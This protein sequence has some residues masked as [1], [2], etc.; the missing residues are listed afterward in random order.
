MKFTVRLLVLSCLAMP[1][2]LLAQKAD[3]YAYQENAAFVPGLYEAARDAQVYL[4]LDA[5]AVE[6]GVFIKKGTRISIYSAGHHGAE[7]PSTNWFN[8]TE[9]QECNGKILAWDN[10]G[11]VGVLGKDFTRIRDLPAPI[12]AKGLITNCAG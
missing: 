10:Y 6:K 9:G 1:T 3:G 12:R 4:D 11:W 8:L 5:K 7:P 2:M